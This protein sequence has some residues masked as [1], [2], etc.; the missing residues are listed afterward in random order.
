MLK[1]QDVRQLATLA[2]I[3]LDDSEV[4]LLRAQL[5]DILEHFQRLQNVDTEEISPTG[6]STIAQ[7]V[8]RV[9]EIEPS[10]LA[11]DTLANAPVRH[12]DFFRVRAVLDGS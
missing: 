12:D 10:L 1:S 11:D 2:R 8:M 5:S 6:H 7:S 4:E 9:D 3:A